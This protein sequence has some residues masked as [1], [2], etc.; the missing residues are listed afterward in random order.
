MRPVVFAGVIPA[1]VA[2]AGIEYQQ[3]KGSHCLRKAAIL[4]ILL[5]S[6]ACS[7]VP[8]SGIGALDPRLAWPCDRL[9]AEWDVGV[10]L[11]ERLVGGK[12]EARQA[13]GAGRLQLHVMHCAPAPGAGGSDRRLS[14]SY[15]VVPVSAS[16]VP[17]AITRV[18]PDGWLYIHKLIA[19][20]DAQSM[21]A[22]LGYD[23]VPA[24]AEFRI[25]EQGEETLVAIELRFARGRIAIAGLATGPAMAAGA[26]SA[27]I[28]SGDGFVSAFF[29]AE[30]FR[31]F[32]ASA[33]VR[34]L[35][36]TPLSQFGLNATP[37]AVKLHR[38]VFSDRVYWRTPAG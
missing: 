7:S 15:V 21:F 26:L 27:I 22:G 10:D 38:G 13:D 16:S 37:A 23:V 8:E 12:V 34:F 11:L 25:D 2:A 32:P 4:A 6:A 28:G 20:G 18:P 3:V 5:G 35:G 36:Q 24:A 14:Y 31:D 19:S 33:T 29:G 1:S 17:I 9:V 30:E